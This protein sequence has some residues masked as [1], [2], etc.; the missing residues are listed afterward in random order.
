MTDGPGDERG[1][2]RVEYA[3]FGARRGV[4]RRALTGLGLGALVIAA[5]VIAVTHSGPR[6]PGPPP[7]VG[8]LNVGHRLLGITAGWQLFGLTERSVVDIQLSTGRVITTALPPPQGS[9]PVSFIVRPD[10]A[11]VRPLDNVTGYLVPDGA[12]ARPL[13]GM[14]ASG[15]LLL[16]G[17]APREEWAS[18]GPDNSLLLVGA[19]DRPTGVTIRFPDPGWGSE[20]AMPDGHG[21]VLVASNT[22]EQYDA[23]AHSLR[24]VGLLV[25]AVGP[26]RWLGLDCSS[27]RCRN[28]VFNP[29]TGRRRALPGAPLHL[30]TWPWPA[31]P[32]SVA[33]DGLV[34]A[35]LTG[36]DRG[37]VTLVEINLST[38]AIHRLPVAASEATSSATMAWSPDSAWLFV[39]T[40]RGK[41][42]AISIRTGQAHTLGVPLPALTQ[43]AL[44]P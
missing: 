6:H 33:P 24:R 19:N 20:V 8:V 22:G 2:G 44:R 25:S 14:L 11:I 9:G 40:A 36:T 21:D 39:L 34:A 29:A 16:P 4:H 17:P 38:G 13:T 1:T 37:A 41:L 35:L 31:Y 32:G 43:L 42:T 3:E 12:P 15:G 23:G 30:L 10:D 26:T 28:V 18:G 27:G 7:P 5:V